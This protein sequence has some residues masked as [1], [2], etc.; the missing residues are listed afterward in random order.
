T[1][2]FA[3]VEFGAGIAAL[4]SFIL[5]SY[6]SASL[7]N[8][9][10]SNETWFHASG[11]DYVIFFFLT[12][13]PAF[14]MGISYPLVG[15]IITNNIRVVGSRM[16]LLSF[17]DTIGSVAGPAVAGFI[18][19]RF[20]DIYLS[21][22]ICVVLNIV[23]GVVLFLL[24]KKW[25][26][27]RTKILIVSG[28]LAVIV[29]IMLFSRGD[30]YRNKSKLYPGENIMAM[31]EGMTATVVV[32]QLKSNYMALSINGAKTAFT[33]PEDQRVHKMLAYLPWFFNPNAK[34]AAVIGFG[35]GITTRCLAE[36]DINTTVAEL[37]PEVL[38]LSNRYFSY[39]NH[40]VAASEKVNV[41]IEDGRSVLLRSQ[42]DF[43][44]I[45][46]NAVHPRLGANLYSYDFYALCRER[47]SDN[48][49]ICQWI[50]T[51][52]MSEREFKSLAH[53]FTA[54]FPYTRLWYVNRA[55]LLIIG[56]QSPL[57]IDYGQ[58]V[59]LFY[60][61]DV[62]NE[63]IDIDLAG[64]GDVLAGF[65]M[66]SQ[67]MKNWVSSATPDTDDKP[68]IE[69]SFVTDPRPDQGILHKLLNNRP[70]F[71]NLIF[72]DDTIDKNSRN[73]ILE[74]IKRDYNEHIDYLKNLNKDL[75]AEDSL[76]N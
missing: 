53:A 40:G 46:S 17:T 36:L 72:F 69:Y 25:S 62:Y 68:V 21:F 29:I 38:S 9:R 52:W 10:M 71:S 2:K 74:K 65:F 44:I 5:F 42:Q 8:A 19:L 57:D 73:Y 37:S 30:Y 18:M 63:M 3:F 60:S 64:P 66:D 15:K 45:T 51:N 47:L 20:L 61:R 35:L 33:N 67:A 50:P 49:I 28:S 4:L 43:D 7:F 54:V 55:H 70:D 11:R 14:F 58:F 26:S 76:R 22:I 23:S 1:E 31:K 48:G 34:N 39:V 24:Y 41:F 12:S 6:L 56:S 75:A 27:S 13:V 59:S 16:G 32:S